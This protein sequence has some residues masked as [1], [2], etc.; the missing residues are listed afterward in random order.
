[1]R[2]RGERATGSSAAPSADGHHAC[3]ML[4]FAADPIIEAEVEARTVA[5]KGERSPLMEVRRN[6][7]RDRV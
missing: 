3:E 7:D 4:A 2:A 5:A 1:M 6:G